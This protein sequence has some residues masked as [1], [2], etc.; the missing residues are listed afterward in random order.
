[1]SADCCPDCGA[2]AYVVVDPLLPDPDH[3]AAACEAP[4]C[5]M[6]YRRASGASR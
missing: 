4:G 1:M 3:V 5:G 6:I 2:E